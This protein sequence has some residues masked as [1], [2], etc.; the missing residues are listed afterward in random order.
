FNSG[1]NRLNGIVHVNQPIETMAENSL[2]FLVTYL[3]A[4]TAVFYYA[5]EENGTLKVLATHALLGPSRIDK[6]ILPG[7]G[8]AGQVAATGKSIRLSAVPHNYLPIGSALGEATPLE[9]LLMPVLHNDTLTAVIELGSFKNFTKDHYEFLLQATEVIGVALNAN[10]SH[11]LVNELLEQTQSQTEELRVQQEELQQTNEEL[12]ERMQM[13]AE[14][15][16]S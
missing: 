5:I 3:D 15:G 14:R 10:H 13:L 8:L 4:S 16:R 11:Q 9:V 6:R 2:G 12:I 1:L 7:E